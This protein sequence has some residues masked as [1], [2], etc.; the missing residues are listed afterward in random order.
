MYFVKNFKHFNELIISLNNT[1]NCAIWYDHMFSIVQF[2]FVSKKINLEN[3]ELMSKVKLSK[4]YY[5]TSKYL[6]IVNDDLGYSLSLVG[7]DVNEIDPNIIANFQ[8][9]LSNLATFNAEEICEITGYN[10]EQLYRTLNIDPSLSH[11]YFLKA[12]DL[13]RVYHEPQPILILNQIKEGCNGESLNEINNI[14]DKYNNIIE[15]EVKSNYENNL[16]KN[17][18]SYFKEVFLR[19]IE[20]V[21]ENK[22]ILDAIDNYLS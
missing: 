2:N 15:S 21:K 20:D 13:I 3:R 1:N 11:Q 4:N 18:S 19:I 9:K 14:I 22:Y 5:I 16:N 17:L 12:V 8:S 7:I 10:L 6:I